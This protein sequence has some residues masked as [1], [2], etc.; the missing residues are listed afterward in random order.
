MGRLNV[1]LDDDLHS[2]FKSY[3]A[4]NGKTMVK[5]I[6][7]FISSLTESGDIE[8]IELSSKSDKSFDLTKYRKA[9]GLEK[10]ESLPPIHNCEV[11]K[12]SEE[13]RANAIVEAIDL[14]LKPI[15]ERLEELKDLRVKLKE[16][17]EEINKNF[18]SY[19]Q[20]FKL[21]EKK[22]VVVSKLI[23]SVMKAIEDLHSGVNMCE[24]DVKGIGF[25][26]GELAQAI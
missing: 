22:F 9:L 1:E 24:D 7:N 3:C 16:T 8:H 10:D 12:M 21:L 4:E 17:S 26:E 2:N 18:S 11:M 19:D 15:R 25:L 23:E 13:E 20:N 5:T 6:S 14:R